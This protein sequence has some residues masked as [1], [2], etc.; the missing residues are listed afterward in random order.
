MKHSTLTGLIGALMH[1]KAREK[2][3]KMEEK[4]IHDAIKQQEMAC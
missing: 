1:D 4:L 2:Q 3:H